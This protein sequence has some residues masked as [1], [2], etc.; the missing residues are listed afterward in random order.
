[1]TAGQCCLEVQG[2]QKTLDSLG[3]CVNRLYGNGL[4]F[5]TDVH[6]RKV[7]TGP[8]K[9]SRD[10][11]CQMK[12]RRRMSGPEQQLPALFPQLSRRVTMQRAPK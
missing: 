9:D 7:N 12:G 11:T 6:G 3:I 4:Y 8:K 2:K 1:M 5:T 10:A